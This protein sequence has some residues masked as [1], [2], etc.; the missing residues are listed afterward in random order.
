MRQTSLFQAGPYA[1][2]WPA[3]EL[4]TTEVWFVVLRHLLERRMYKWKENGRSN[5]GYEKPSGLLKSFPSLRS[6]SS[7]QL[8]ECGTWY[9]VQ[10]YLIWESLSYKQPKS[11]PVP[12]LDRRYIGQNSLKQ[13]T[14]QNIASLR[15]KRIGWIDQQSRNKVVHE[16]LEDVFD[17][18]GRN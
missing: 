16:T 4:G 17:C 12:T 15:I 1:E 6:N 8:P 10:L 18:R 13:R 2:A 9:L 11:C 3:S 5:E 7:H 14:R